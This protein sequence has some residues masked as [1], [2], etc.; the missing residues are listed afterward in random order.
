MLAR[1]PGTPYLPAV[2]SRETEITL[3]A[4]R[5]HARIGVLPHEREIEQPVEIDLT[6]WVGARPAGGDVLDYRVLYGLASAAFDRG[7]VD[8]LEDVAE[9]V[10]RR[11]LDVPR[12]SR[13]R[14][15]VRKP[16]VA[17]AGPLAYAQVLVDR[18]R[19]AP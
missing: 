12:V 10:A 16:H 13:A 17:L 2:H 15:A 19:E 18:D 8:F 7:H 1:P 11:A 9:D 4:M 14:V 3:S 5:F 6:V